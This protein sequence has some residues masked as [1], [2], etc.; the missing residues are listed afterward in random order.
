MKAG[1]WKGGA[2]ALPTRTGKRLAVNEAAPELVHLP[3]CMLRYT[4]VRQLQQPLV[5]VYTCGPT[6]LP[7]APQDHPIQTT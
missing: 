3:H 7:A 6:G 2:D 5:Y 1:G 4:C